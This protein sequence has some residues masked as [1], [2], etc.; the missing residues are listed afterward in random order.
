MGEKEKIER[1]AKLERPQSPVPPAQCLSAT[2]AM[3]ERLWGCSL[4]KDALACLGAHRLLWEK[5][6]IPV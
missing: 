3:W 5:E 2:G 1:L 6:G 4:R